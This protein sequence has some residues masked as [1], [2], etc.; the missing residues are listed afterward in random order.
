MKCV[1]SNTTSHGTAGAVQA[2]QL[3]A[4]INERA[5][6]FVDDN[7]RAPTPSDYL[8]V[9]TAMKIG[10]SLAHEVETQML[11]EQ[12]AAAQAQHTNGAKES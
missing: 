3:N 7:Y 6:A 4:R 2:G 1:H 12:I 5:R 10:A 8:I 11:R 9:N